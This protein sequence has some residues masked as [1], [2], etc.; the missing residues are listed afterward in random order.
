MPSSADFVNAPSLTDTSR[1][2]T[3]QVPPASKPQTQ[4]VDVQDNSPVGEPKQTGSIDLSVLPPEK[5]SKPSQP[6]KP[7]SLP[8]FPAPAASPVYTNAAGKAKT[9]AVQ[10][11][12]ADLV[13]S[14]DFSGDALT[15]QA[16]R[17]EAPTAPSGPGITQAPD[18][19]P[20]VTTPRVS[21]QPLAQSI[22]GTQAPAP[23]SGL[24][25]TQDPTYGQIYNG[26]I[27]GGEYAGMT[28]NQ[29]NDAKAQV[30]DIYKKFD[31]QIAAQ[32][33]AAKEG[34]AEALVRGGQAGGLLSTQI[35]GK[36]A[37]AVG[38]NWM[39]AGGTL[40]RLQ[41]QYDQAIADMRATEAQAA[42]KAKA[43]AI[44]AARTGNQADL[45]AATQA[46]SSLNAISS[47]IQATS[48]DHLTTLKNLSS[49]QQLETGNASTTIGNLV[50]NGYEVK[51]LPP[52]YLQ[53]LDRHLQAGGMPPG[54]VEML[55][56]TQKKMKAAQDITDEL[57]RQKAE[58]DNAKNIV[59]M[60][61]DIPMGKS[62]QIGGQTYT[63]LSKGDLQTG[64]ETDNQGKVTHWSF[65]PDDGTTISTDLGYIGTSK[66]GYT[67]VQTDQG[68]FSYNPKTGVTIPMQ[69][70]QAQT[71][72]QTLFPNGSQSPFR[73]K[74]DPN[75]GQCAAFLND[76]YGQRILG[77][78]FDQKEKT[79][80]QYK[81]DP[82]DVQV[83]DTFL[84]SAGS[85]GHVGIVAGVTQGPNG[86]IITAL[87]SNY[88][89]PGK[90]VIS[91]TR[92]MALNDPKLKMLA[93]VPTPKLPS[94]GPDSPWT[95][96]AHGAPTIGGR[97]ISEVFGGGGNVDDT[98]QLL[99]S[100]DMKLT[101]VPAADRA[102]ALSIAKEKYGY[103]SPVEDI[104]QGIM[105]GTIPPDM[106]GL[107]GQG[108]AVHAELAKRGYNLTK[109]TQDYQATTS[110]LK[111]LNSASQ[112]RLRQAVQFSYD[113]LDLLDQ[114]NQEWQRG[115]FGPFNAAQMKAAASGALGQQAQSIATRFDNQVADM[116]SELGTVYKGGNSPTD[117]SLEKAS[118]MF[119]TDWSEQT[120]ADNVN[121]V[122]QN[123]GIRKNSLAQVGA[124][125]ISGETIGGTGESTS[126]PL[127]LGITP[128]DSSG[129]G[130]DASSDPLN[131]GF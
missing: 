105:D 88:V 106:K 94:A 31:P 86:P 6:S 98:A 102:K 8:F 18:T 76:L 34:E 113:S 123:L 22:Q 49:I 114:L 63:G 58:V 47:N 75:Q 116:Q 99:A 119:D 131:L 10:K 35:A 61:K 13:S 125:G 27:T 17:M 95:A 29:A 60:L 21:Y 39:G 100:G 122:R 42:A 46:Q 15:P 104:A 30:S 90:G 112:V 52:A 83:G 87:E 96:L 109:A 108:P 80:S 70:T 20:A 107:Y 40:G 36:A 115:G 14:Y 89:P 45:D 81:I 37:V 110:Y 62:I 23:G 38:E 16:Q 93:R 7:T 57:G 25:Y 71:T 44:T 97:P 130:G 117:A 101:D 74:S 51:D 11:Q 53:D 3:G 85:T 84:M 69:P 67:P 56:A 91:S 124:V 118:K 1:T 103:Q 28:I 79:L 33:K 9:A 64:T 127:N 77:D 82:K 111:T 43:Y 120:F 48:N 50:A 59:G 41:Q 66:D 65:N 121:L 24:G 128:T 126:D 5:P 26:V 129:G 68:W 54:S 19:T 72:W 55:F 92:T 2:T 73:D 12:A 4:F 32:E 78:T